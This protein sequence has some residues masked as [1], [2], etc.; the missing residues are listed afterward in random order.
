[1]ACSLERSARLLAV[2]AA[3]L[4]LCSLAV[5]AGRLCWRAA[6]DCCALVTGRLG[7]AGALQA[8]A[9]PREQR[10]A[11]YL[12]CGGPSVQIAVPYAGWFP[13]QGASLAPLR[14][15]L[16]VR[17]AAGVRS[18]SRRDLTRARSP[19]CCA[20][21]SRGT[22]VAF[23]VLAGGC[24]LRELHTDERKRLVATQSRCDRSPDEYEPITGPRPSAVA[25][26]NGAKRVL[27]TRQDCR[28]ML[29][30]HLLCNRRC[31]AVSGCVSCASA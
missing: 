18:D 1:M 16:A 15:S 8:C 24:C 29:T 27:A 28:L 19:E 13:L 11:A 2:V 21:F 17:G 22:A 26:E 4:E 14:W 5:A 9:S 10:P 23:P 12:S 7:F 20:S 30:T 3:G 31:L 6:G 25:V